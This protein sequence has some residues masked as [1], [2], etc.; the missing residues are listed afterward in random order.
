MEA[1]FSSVSCCVSG[2]SWLGAAIPLFSNI[3][4]HLFGRARKPNFRRRFRDRGRGAFLHESDAAIA[5]E[6][7]LQHRKYFT[8]Y[9]DHLTG[10]LKHVKRFMPPL[11]VWLGAAYAGKTP[12][13][14]DE[15]TAKQ[16]IVARTL[17]HVSS[18]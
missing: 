2:R 14:V 18:T 3:A 6:T 10:H 8:L 11:R 13:N 7:L 16:Y 5:R 15:T 4:A 9:N 12:N 1:I 17:T